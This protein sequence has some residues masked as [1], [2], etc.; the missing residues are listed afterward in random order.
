[1]AQHLISNLKDLKE[2]VKEITDHDRLA[3]D[4]ETKGPDDQED[5]SGL[6]PF[7]GARAFAHI[8][9]TAK[10]EYYF[11]FN[12]GGINP[13]YKERLQPIFDDKGRIIFYCN[14]IF[15]ATISHFDG[16]VFNQRIVDWPAIARVEYN[17]HG[18]QAW[19]DESFLSMEYLANYYNVKLKDDRVKQY[20]KDH[21]LYREQRCRFTGERIPDYSI[22]PLEGFMFEYG[23][24]D[25]RTTF[26]GPTKTIK[27]INYK[28]EQYKAQRDD[29]PLMM[30]IAKNEIKLTS[31]LVDMK[32]KGMRVW[33]EYV[34]RALKHE[35][36]TSE[37]LHSEIDKLTGGINLNSGKQVAEFLIKHGVDVPRK[38]VT[39]TATKRCDA[40]IEK[41]SILCDELKTKNL[42]S[43]SKEIKLRKIREAELKIEEYRKGNPQTD[44]KT[45]EILT[46]Q[47]PELDF[48]CKISKA[49][50]ADKKI[51][52][53]YENF[54]L[55][56]DA[57]DIIH[58]GFNQEK[59]ITGRFSS[60]D[61]NLQNVEKVYTELNDD[62]FSVR[63]SF[64]ADKG[65]RLFFFDFDQ[66]EMMFMLD[67]AEEMGIIEKLKSGEFKD[68]YLATADQI[69]K[70]LGIII[71]RAA[72]KAMALGL[73]YGK[74]LELLGRELGYISPNADE[75]EIENGKK[76]VKVFKDNFFKALP[77]LKRLEQNLQNQVKWYGKFHNAFGRVAYM[78][79]EESYKALN[80]FVQGGSADIIKYCMVN[81]PPLLIKADLKT[82]L[83]LC[84]HDELIF[85]IPIGEEENAIPSIKKAMSA[86][87]KHKHIPLTVG[88]DYSPINKYGVSAWGEKTTWLN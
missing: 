72:A 76:E 18:K 23:C 35:R 48:L 14:A 33:T 55:L 50:E 9:A 42:N 12:T 56:K 49:K 31:V 68:F 57:N 63:K 79:K 88:V 73:S 77:K 27:C 2:A 86:A 26:D 22:V 30:D 85:N 24:G 45:L 39:E 74:G 75:Y 60:S 47:H 52:T 21:E 43:K 46:R 78:S 10:D 11:N 80:S 64:I 3:H 32:I 81:I 59:A 51:G 37:V 17:R 16:L 71:L 53:Y 40:W 44:K 84:V 5:I 1:M 61:P 38:K 19:M 87:Y 66:E 65:C 28:D 34:E 7:H 29:K 62:R 58:C 6:Y 70:L 82:R 20:I 67:Q 69:K 36:K 8:I 4:T 25:G 15:D 41:H 54:I 13:K 83:T